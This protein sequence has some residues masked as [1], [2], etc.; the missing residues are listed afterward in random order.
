MTQGKV[1]WAYHLVLLTSGPRRSSC[2]TGVKPFEGHLGAN[3]KDA[4]FNGMVPSCIS[5]KPKKAPDKLTSVR[6]S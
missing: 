6:Q 2:S 5:R 3:L 4:I 1:F